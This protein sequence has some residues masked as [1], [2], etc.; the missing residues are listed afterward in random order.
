MTSEPASVTSQRREPDRDEPLESAKIPLKYKGLDIASQM[1]S[2]KDAEPDLARAVGDYS[3]SV[4]QTLGVI[5][6]IEKTLLGK[7]RQIDEIQARQRVLA[8]E[9]SDLGKSLQ[10][11]THD[12]AQQFARIISD[13]ETDRPLAEPPVKKGP[14]VEA[15][16]AA[17]PADPAVE[18]SAAKAPDAE[19]KP[20]D[21]GPG[22]SGKAPGL[23]LDASD[24]PPVPEFLG[25]RQRTLDQ[26]DNG[27]AEGA[28]SGSRGWWKHSRKG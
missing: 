20:T 6:A 14:D 7:R 18:P 4:E 15:A 11:A 24:L 9:Y 21:K 22:E 8:R 26:S 5:E 10:S 12:L 25:D 17:L 28:G 2:V 19:H 1:R 16:S 23:G 3:A 13:L 27:D